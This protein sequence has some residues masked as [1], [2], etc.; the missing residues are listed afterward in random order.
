M[1]AAPE[2][3]DPNCGY[4]FQGDPSGRAQCQRRWNVAGQLSSN[5]AAIAA[6]ISTVQKRNPGR[7]GQALMEQQIEYLQS[8]QGQAVI[9]FDPSTG[10]SAVVYGDLAYSSDVVIVLDGTH[11][12]GTQF[13]AGAEAKAKAIETQVCGPATSWSSCGTAS[14]AFQYNPPSSALAA[15]LQGDAP[16]RRAAGAL[17]GLTN[18]VRSDTAQGR[19]TVVGHSYGS[20]VVGLALKK[21]LDVDAAIFTGSSGEEVNNVGD[22][23][24]HADV[25]VAQAPDDNLSHTLY[26]YSPVVLFMFGSCKNMDYFGRLPSDPSFGAIPLDVSG[27]SGHNEYFTGQSL[28][29]I[30]NVVTVR[31]TNNP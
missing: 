26:C 5:Q 6:Q 7:N 29:S 28:I 18:T 8:L 10:R 24:T 25:F 3:D 20:L 22:F 11:S 19:V 4:E 1:K 17:I 27:S 16:A 13:A 31:L 23:H 30:T 15:V 14:I 2:P 12:G 9:Y 21:G